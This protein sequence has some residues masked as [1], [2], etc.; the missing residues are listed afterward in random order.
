MS[1]NVLT[2]SGNCG[3]DMEVRATPA[4]KYIGQVNLAVKSGYGQHEKTAWVTC[5]VL[6][7][8][9]SKLAQYITKGSMI[10]VTGSLEID[11]WTNKEGAKQTRVVCVVNDIQLPVRQGGDRPQA[12]HQQPASGG[13]DF[14]D[15]IPFAAIGAEHFS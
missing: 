4:G 15:D 6:G 8:R 2:I 5:K 3:A 10:T 11:E 13:V 14:D 9:A 12:P 7:E 1:I